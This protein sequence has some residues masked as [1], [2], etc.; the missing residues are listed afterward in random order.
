MEKQRCKLSC[1]IKNFIF[2]WQTVATFSINGSATQYKKYVN[3]IPVVVSRVLA[4][5]F[6]CNWRCYVMLGQR[7][8]LKLVKSIPWSLDSELFLRQ[9]WLF[10][11]EREILT[12]KSKNELSVSVFSYIHTHVRYHLGTSYQPTFWYKL[13]Y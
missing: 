4:F 8:T 10:D 7:L 6:T 12:F 2:L 5:T 11:L 3:F 9:P 1:M 13:I